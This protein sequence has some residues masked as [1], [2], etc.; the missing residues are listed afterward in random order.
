MKPK[1]NPLVR[2]SFGLIMLT[3]SMLF[4]GDWL[5]LVPDRQ[6]VNLEVR[7]KFSESLAIQFSSLAQSGDSRHIR[8]TLESLI[9]RNPEV[10]SAAFR[11][12]SDGDSIEVGDHATHWTLAADAVKSTADQVIVPIYRGNERWG[13]LE[14]RYV[15]P[16]DRWY[17]AITDDSFLALVLFIALSG[18]MLYMLFLRRVLRELDP[19]KVIPDRVKHAFNT[20][21][22]GVM[23]LDEEGQIVLANNA[24]C[25]KSALD[26][27]K[28]V[29]M[30]A[31]DLNWSVYQ[32]QTPVLDDRLPWMRVLSG[33]KGLT[34]EKL[35]MHGGSNLE[36]SY[37][38]NCTPIRDEGG[39]VR[40]VITT[41]DD[42]TELE[43][44]NEVLK[45][46][47]TDLKQTQFDVEMKNKELQILAT[48]D[49]L[50]GVLNRRSF[51]DQLGALYDASREY[52]TDLVCIMVDIDHFKRINDNYGHSVGDKII[53]FVADVLGKQ[54]RK[55]DLVARYGGEEYC[56]VLDGS[57]VEHAITVAE[58][59]RKEITKGDPGVFT[60]SLRVTASFGIAA[61]DD[62]V[63]SKEALIN[64]ADRALYLAKE[65]GRNKVSVWE[66]ETAA[67]ARTEAE[68]IELADH[69]D[70]AA[71]QGASAE[72]VDA[73]ARIQ[74]LERIAQ[75]KA[76]LLDQY[77]S[78][79]AL[80]NLPE[81]NLFIDRIDQALHRAEREGH[82]LAVISLALD[83]LRRIND[84]LGYE[85][86]E[87][88]L[89]IS[90]ERLRDALRASDAISLMS[91]VD[92]DATI[93]KLSE[94][95]FGL[96]LPVVRDSESIAWIIKRMLDSLQENIYLADHNITVSA[97]VGI[98]VFPNDG[99]DAVA[100]IR[101]AS[102]SRYYAEQQPGS[103]NVEYYSE[104]INR[105]SR[106]Q[107]H[108]ESQMADAIDREEFTLLYQPKID[109]VS[110]EI[111]GFESL[112]RWNHPTRGVL[113]PNEFIDIAERTRMINLI[114]DWVM[115][116]SCRQVKAF[117]AVSSRPLSVS[118]NMSPVQF[119]QPDLVGKVMGILEREGVGAD[120][121]EIELTENCL[122]DRVD[123]AFDI[124]GK[125]QYNGISVS[126]DDFGTGY[127][128]LS[129]LRT[130]PINVLKVD[131][132][133]VAD[134][135]SDG[136]DT[137]IVAAIISMAKALELK[138]VAEGVETAGQLQTLRR[139]GCEEAQG[140]LFSRPIPAEEALKL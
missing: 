94:S 66:G 72:Q 37:A 130:L 55:G 129:Y 51:T 63:D 81:R 67:P 33:G 97:N 57:S 19:S 78:H 61:L 1:M 125:L 103:N 2:V 105:V 68:I 110:N 22:E 29:G 4:V 53:K 119:S 38:V 80:T 85:V 77:V 99:D 121:L 120:Q 112:I 128:G 106:Q 49:A 39:E 54:V 73:S 102:V 131:R 9:K 12:L 87:K 118:V 132:C 69:L 17:S 10:G 101:N 79:D 41:F 83:N 104:D 86:A 115:R 6:S 135:D 48:R 24:F 127:S 64:N 27:R 96:L 89:R 91:P 134:I 123:L 75:E 34:G 95:E 5:G 20:L 30:K 137:A 45:K 114:G 15:E 133:F 71:G 56:V 107:M 50:T 7:K 82:V 52:S 111:C 60:S 100:L 98:G 92:P 11:F 90:A 3:L 93:S 117:N 46:T 44:R 21:A 138:V 140:Y 76:D 8:T 109:L 58:R 136:H 122:L 62:T 42:L 23:I 28:V 65:S 13:S 70:A 116:E 139:L 31:R 88:V 14:L 40:G 84:N 113:T 18:F 25:D 26:E 108:L 16:S 74:E 43:E 32:T 36:R 126:I 35:T 47:L 59:M 124:L